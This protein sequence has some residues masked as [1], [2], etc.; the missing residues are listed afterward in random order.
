[1]ALRTYWCVLQQAERRRSG[2]LSWDEAAGFNCDLDLDLD[3]GTMSGLRTALITGIQQLG[4]DESAIGW[5]RLNV[6][7]AEGNVAVRDYVAPPDSPS[8]PP[9]RNAPTGS[10]SPSWPGACS[11]GDI[12]QRASSW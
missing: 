10:S 12:R 7:D 2:K 1:M 11:S 4:G 8:R 3:G 5:Y 9:S 6:F